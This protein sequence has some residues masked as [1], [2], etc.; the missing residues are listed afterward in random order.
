MYP[1]WICDRRVSASV[2]ISLSTLYMT[3]FSTD[4]LQIWYGGTVWLWH[5]NYRFWSQYS[6][7]CG[8]QRAKTKIIVYCLVKRSTGYS[9]QPIFFIFDMLLVYGKLTPPIDFGWHIVTIVTTRGPRVKIAFFLVISPELLDRMPSYLT[10]SYI[11]IH[12]D[13]IQ[14][15]H[16]IDG[17]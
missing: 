3:Q 17:L 1:L 5:E 7:N 8:H 14:L 6:S 16:K 12:N 4:F 9:S 2:Q 15:R 10:C 11:M 13:K